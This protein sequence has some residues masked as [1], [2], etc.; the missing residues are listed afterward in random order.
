MRSWEEPIS[1]KKPK[2]ITKYQVVD[3]EG[4]YVLDPYFEKRSAEYMSTEYFPGSTVIEVEEE[5][6]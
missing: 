3:K 2:F 1:K 5:V 6:K 4:N